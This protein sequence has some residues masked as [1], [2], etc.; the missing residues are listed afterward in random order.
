MPIF[1]PTHT[2]KKLI[3]SLRNVV[4]RRSVNP[5]GAARSLKTSSS[6]RLFFYLYTASQ[7]IILIFGFPHWKISLSFEE[8][9]V[10]F[11]IPII[12]EM[13]F[14]LSCQLQDHQAD[15][16]T[17]CCF[18]GVEGLPDRIVTGSRD[19]TAKL[20]ALEDDSRSKYR[21]Q[22]TF[23]GHR[24][25]VTVVCA[26]PASAD[27]V[28]GNPPAKLF[29]FMLVSA[30]RT[31]KINSDICPYSF[32]GKMNSPARNSLIMGSLIY[33]EYHRQVRNTNTFR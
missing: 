13:S 30:S 21:L 17:V 16:R 15:V 24:S 11:S 25:Y 4:D 33:Y 26:I 23:A 12:F 27:H 19:K 5:R 6:A 2:E 22:R 3:Q 20:W 28:E 10:S 9:F 14:Q 32:P 1:F 18:P 31:I 7:F 8:K 29:Y